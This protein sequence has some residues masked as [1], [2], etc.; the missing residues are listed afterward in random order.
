MTQCSEQ[1][2]RRQRTKFLNNLLPLYTEV[3]IKMKAATSCENKYINHNKNQISTNG[4]NFCMCYGH[5]R[6]NISTSAANIGLKMFYVKR[7]LTC[8]AN[9]PAANKGSCDSSI[10]SNQTTRPCI[11]EDNRMILLTSY[12]PSL[13]TPKI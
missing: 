13:H 4:M 12:S 2:S 3:I 11:L 10:N 5:F 6:L 9:R 8:D 7:Q 1:H